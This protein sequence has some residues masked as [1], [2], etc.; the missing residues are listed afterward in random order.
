MNIKTNKG[1]FDLPSGFSMPIEETSPVYNDRGSQSLPVTVPA[2][3][4]NNRLAGFPTRPDSEM[5][6]EAGMEPCVVAD[7]SYIRSGKLNIVS[8]GRRDGISFNVGFDNSTAYDDWSKKK[9][10]DLEGLPSITIPEDDHSDIYD[11]IMRIYTDGD[12]YRDDLAVFPL[13]V[14]NK[15]VEI[16]TGPPANVKET[17]FYYELLNNLPNEKYR[18]SRVVKRIVNGEVTEITVPH[19]YGLT[20]FVKLWKVVEL[21]FADSGYRLDANPFKDDKELAR[22]VVLNNTVDACCRDRLDF[23]DL[24]PD[25]TVEEFLQSLWTRFGFVYSLDCDT[26][27]ARP[28]LVRDII[29]APHGADF[30]RLMTDYPLVTYETPQYVKLSASASFEGAA[31]LT[32]RFEDFVKGYS[33]DNVIF[34]RAIAQWGWRDDSDDY[35]YDW[36]EYNDDTD[37]DPDEGREE[38]DYDDW[39]DRYWDDYDDWGMDDYSA[40]RAASQSVAHQGEDTPETPREKGRLA[41]EVVTSLWFRLDRENHLVDTASSSFFNWD[42]QTVGAEAM[43]LQ[44]VDE[45]VP[46]VWV[47]DT[48]SEY[49]TGYV[50]MFL[51]GSRFR[52]TYIS[53]GED[54]KDSDKGDSTPLAFLFAFND[55]DDVEQGTIGRFSPE[56][57]QGK[58]MRFRDGSVATLSL[59]FQFPNGLFARFWKDFDELLRHGARY[60]EVPAAIDKSVL[61]NLDILSPVRYD[62]GRYLVDKISYS[63]PG[64][65]AVM[66]D[67]T[68]RPLLPSGHYDLVV[69]QGIPPFEPGT[70]QNRWCYVSNDIREVCMSRTSRQAAVDKWIEANAAP[71]GH[72]RYYAKFIRAVPVYPE[73]YQDAANRGEAQVGT[74]VRRTYKAVA[75]YDIYYEKMERILDD[76][77]ELLTRWVMSESPCGN[78]EKTVS[79][80]VT[81]VGKWV[82]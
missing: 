44:S 57:S 37:W 66:A 29:K 24:M 8:A 27:V 20:A 81:L 46:L 47:T 16:E 70:R 74:E 60:V 58:Y 49:F 78:V 6:P 43:E 71:T 14:D 55:C 52:H 31:P 68:L 5:V 56:S 76:S 11:V 53:K 40:S 80:T 62:N 13:A 51:A 19:F 4:S 45:W 48:Y 77:G 65:K 23:S 9:L 1:T 41:F 64:D 12:N 17:R 67:L 18:N 54:D 2:T 35:D 63:L 34:G 21:V 73:W 75:V 82:Q 59:L 15:S 42:P 38:W 72:Y 32:E 28:R 26:M 30:S 10:P 3:P 39:D 79:Y 33:L 22:I 25:V 69:E 61:R 7:G 36:P 50:P